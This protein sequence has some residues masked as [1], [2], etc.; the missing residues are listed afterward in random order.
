MEKKRVLITGASGFIG[1]V[2]LKEMLKNEDIDFFAIDTRKIPNISIEKL[3]L[4]SLLDKEK[5]MEIIKRYKPNIIIHLAAIALVT[6]DNVGEIYNVNVQGT[7]NLLEVTQEYCDKG[8]R[9]ILASTAG[10]YGNQNVDKYREDLS[11]NPANHYSYSKMITEYISKQ[12]KEDL[13]IVTIRPFNIIGVGQSEKFLVP[14]LVEHFAD[15]KEKLSVG[16]I[17][18]FRDYVDVEYCAEV[19]MELISRK[20]LD[21]DILNICSGIPTNGE[22]I[23]QLLQE[24]TDFKPEIEISSDF[25]RKNEVWRMIGD[26]TRL[27]EFM[28]NK[29]PQSVKDILVKMLDYYKNR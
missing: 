19:I 5:L 8:T 7:E 20:K 27:W 28:N 15:K 11:Y 13:D 3:E 6:H 21:F 14:K 22:M 4:V 17:S 12:Y 25:V 18:S 23:I 1:Q 10:V 29:K 9:V 2:V 26:T 16:N 24:I